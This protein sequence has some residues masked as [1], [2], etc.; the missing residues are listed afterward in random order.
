[1][2]SHDSISGRIILWIYLLGFLAFACVDVFFSKLTALDN[3]TAVVLVLVALLVGRKYRITKAA[4]ICIGL[5]FVPNLL[6][7][8]GGYSLNIFEYN[9][10]KIVHLFTAFFTSISLFLFVRANSRK[11]RLYKIATLAFVMTIAFGAL[12]EVA[13]YWGFVFI[14][15]G[16]GYLGFGSGDS[17]KNFGPWEDS[18]VDTTC[19]VAGSLVGVFAALLAIRIKKAYI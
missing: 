12:V 15:F 9:Y 1:M 19:N 3:L 10:D 13:E 18:S 2:R 16:D 6:G 11:P 7:H 14:G 8:L 17:G 5:V 4:A